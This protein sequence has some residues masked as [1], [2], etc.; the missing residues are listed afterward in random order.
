M[1]KLELNRIKS[2]LKAE[3]RASNRAFPKHS[4]KITEDF[5][6]DF[7]YALCANDYDKD[8]DN[9]LTKMLKTHDAMAYGPEKFSQKWDS[10]CDWVT[11]K[12]FPELSVQKGKIKEGNIINK[13]KVENEIEEMMEEYGLSKHD[14]LIEVLSQ[15]YEAAGINSKTAECILSNMSEPQLMDRYHEIAKN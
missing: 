8:A 15:Y 11:K 3:Y 4:D 5:L 12:Y 6:C 2:E 13:K 7:A 1:K 9:L 10:F 14:M